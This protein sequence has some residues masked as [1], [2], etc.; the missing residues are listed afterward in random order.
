[1]EFELERWVSDGLLHLL[2]EDVVRADDYDI[3]LW[4][5]AAWLTVFTTDDIDWDNEECWT[6]V[7]LVEFLQMVFEERVSRDRPNH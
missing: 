4:D 1:M 7:N 5:G 2:H 3:V 6:E